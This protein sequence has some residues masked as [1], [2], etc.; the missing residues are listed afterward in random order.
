[1]KSRI[2]IVGKMAGG[3]DTLK[4][5][6]ASRGFKP[7]VSFT[8]RPPREGEVDGESYYFI[9]RED[10]ERSIARGSMYEYVE[11]NGWYYGTTKKQ[12]ESDDVFIMTPHG[13]SKL[14]PEDRK[15]SWIIYLDVDEETQRR[16]ALER[17]D[18]PGDN[19]E[20][21]IKADYEDFKDFTDYDSRILGSEITSEWLMKPREE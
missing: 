4:N 21:R 2:I 10:F 3:K 6:L 20:R 12:M 7:T 9:T 19:I 8:T 16:R 17:G 18:M 13:V 11:F 1:M 15:N 5:L 14:K